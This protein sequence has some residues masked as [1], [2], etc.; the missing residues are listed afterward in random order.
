MGFISSKVASLV[1]LVYLYCV[2]CLLFNSFLFGSMRILRVSMSSGDHF[3]HY[4]KLLSSL[5]LVISR[6]KKTVD[7]TSFNLMQMVITNNTMDRLLRNMRT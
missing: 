1:L 5:V 3:I 6:L 4:K 7:T 2:Y